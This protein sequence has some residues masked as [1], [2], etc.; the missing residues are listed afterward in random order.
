MQEVIENVIEWAND[1]DII[2]LSSPEKQILKTIEEVQETQDAINNMDFTKGKFDNII[3]G[4]GDTVVTL[5]ILCEMYN[6]TLQE[7]TE[8][9]YKQ[10]KDRK[11]KMIDG[12]FVKEV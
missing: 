8:Y 7:C 10:I 9:A 4:I 5:I 6:I 2:G 3:D 12:I 11:G 1:R